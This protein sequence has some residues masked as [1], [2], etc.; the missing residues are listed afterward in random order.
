MISI[1]PTI[2]AETPEAYTLQLQSVLPFA[3]RIHIDLMDGKFAPTTSIRPDQMWWP[4]NVRVDLHVMYK[5]PFACTDLFVAL[6]PQ[7]V[8]VHA[9]STGN[10]IQFAETLHRHGIETGVALLPETPV[11]NIASALDSIDHV[12]IFSG[13]LGHQG[14]SK[15]DSNLLPKITELR[16]LKP[17]LEIG[18][19]GGINARNAATLVRYGVDVLNVGGFMHAGES[20]RQQYDLLQN[21]LYA[22]PQ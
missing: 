15:A 16:E 5:K 7:M 2:T 20:P 19:D 14:G 22:R 11:A 17:T 3:R 8:I 1:A 12:L 6:G 21:N 4:G 18:W 10:F 9:E 13:N